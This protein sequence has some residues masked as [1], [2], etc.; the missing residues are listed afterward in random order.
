MGES[1]DYDAGVDLNFACSFNL[2]WY[3]YRNAQTF[4]H[5]QDDEFLVED[6]QGLRD[7]RQESLHT[8][9]GRSEDRLP[10]Q[11]RLI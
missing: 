4:I 10:V 8:V 6:F 7:G 5:R 11:V 1:E 2:F 3:V 9:G